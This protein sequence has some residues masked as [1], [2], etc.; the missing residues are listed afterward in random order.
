MLRLMETGG[1]PNNEILI[2][3]FIIWHHKKNN[4]YISTYLKNREHVY[5]PLG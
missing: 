2:N 1:K 4:S 5:T 3:I